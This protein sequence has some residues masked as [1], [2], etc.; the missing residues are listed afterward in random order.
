[1]FSVLN[2]SMA[3]TFDLSIG[4]QTSDPRH[5]FISR[6]SFKFVIGIGIVHSSVIRGDSTTGVPF[7]KY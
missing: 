3:I 4:V 5:T 2:A 1:M 7:S 6:S